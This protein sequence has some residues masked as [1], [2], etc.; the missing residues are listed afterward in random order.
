M[1]LQ[2]LSIGI[3]VLVLRII[4]FGIYFLMLLFVARF[5]WTVTKK[6]W[7]SKDQ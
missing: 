1:I 4:Q 3:G 6:I 7:N 2:N 5:G